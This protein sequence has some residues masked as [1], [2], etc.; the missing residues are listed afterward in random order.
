VGASPQGR[1]V[2]RAAGRRRELRAVKRPLATRTDALP[3]LFISERGQ[4]LTRQSVNHLTG[5]AAGRASLPAVHPHIL[6]HSG[7]FA[8]A[9]KGYDLRLIQ[10]DLGHRNPRHTAH[11]TRT[12]GQCFEGL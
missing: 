10:D 6:R 4:P 3:W 12:A 7:G 5:V 2:S 9:N 11:Y 1:A 8:L